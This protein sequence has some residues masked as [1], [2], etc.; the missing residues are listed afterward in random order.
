MAIVNNSA[1]RDGDGRTRAATIADILRHEIHEGILRPGVKLNE[2]VLA[3]RFGVS[4]G[5]VREALGLLARDDM[6][7]ITPHIGAFVTE[8]SV[9]EVADLYDVRTALFSMAVR[10]FA[11]RYA[12]GQLTPAEFAET[13]AV[14][15][16]FESS[17]EA[18][19]E[20]FARRSRAVSQFVFAH[21]GN[22]MLRQQAERLN[23]Q[24]ILYFVM[25]TKRDMAHRRTF[26]ALAVMLRQALILG[27]ADLAASL[28]QKIGDENKRATYEQIGLLQAAPHPA[29]GEFFHG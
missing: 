8:L 1:R 23:R 27:D 19:A 6:V 26:L 15:D 3:E 20:D 17:A 29:E 13:H 2:E 21:C 14:L 12:E 28:A 10:L 25:V 9:E 16:A 7:R 4:R 24:S 22:A 11:R 18:N 5:P